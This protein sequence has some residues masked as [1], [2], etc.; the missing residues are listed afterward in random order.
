MHPFDVVR[1]AGR[2]FAVVPCR[3]TGR[4]LVYVLH[5][6][7]SPE[8]LRLALNSLN[9]VAGDA[10][11]ADELRSRLMGAQTPEQEAKVK[12]S[13]ADAIQSRQAAM[14]SSVVTQ[15][16]RLSEIMGHA[17][18]LVMA[19]VMAMGIALDGVADGLQP[20]G[21]MARDI[22]EPLEEVT[23]SRE[24]MYLRPVRWQGPGDPQSDG[25]DIGELHER[26]RLS[27]AALVKEAFGPAKAAAAT[28]PGQGI[29][30]KGGPVG[31]PVQA[32]T[33]R[34]APV[35]RPRGSGARSGGDAGG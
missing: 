29:A 9:A 5:R 2:R 19:S 22:C 28:F 33:E 20:V 17:D 15:P 21:T 10:E 12:A 30:G 18:R 34:V 4:S 31:A 16:D 24:P 26:E 13:V 27:L 6:V 25:F 7:G 11:Q 14:V 8:F 23:D 1:S 3:D 32:E 35:R